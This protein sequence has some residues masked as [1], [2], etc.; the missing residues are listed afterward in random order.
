MNSEL[1]IFETDD[2]SITLDVN[3]GDDSV[4]VTQAQMVNLFGRDKSVISRHV[5][6][7]FRDGGTGERINCCKNSNSC[8]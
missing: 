4:W 3:I 5:N 6:N 2:G 8:L 7:V 1:A